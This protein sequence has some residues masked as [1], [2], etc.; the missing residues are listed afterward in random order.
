MSLQKGMMMT[1]KQRFPLESADPTTTGSVDVGQGVLITMGTVSV[2]VFIVGVLVAIGLG[3]TTS[4]WVTGLN[5]IN[6]PFDRDMARLL[7][8]QAETERL[9][10]E[11]PEGDLRNFFDDNWWMV[12]AA[13]NTRQFQ[14]DASQVTAGA[15]PNYAFPDQSG[16]VV[17]EETFPPQLTEFPE[18]VFAIVGDPDTTTRIQFDLT[19]IPSGVARQYQW[20]DEDGVVAM[21]DDVNVLTGNTTV[22]M[23]TCFMLVNGVDNT[24]TMQFNAGLLT[25]A[26]LRTFTFPPAGGELWL[27]DQPQ[28]ISQKNFD[29]SNTFVKAS[30]PDDVVYEGDVQ[31]ISNKTMDTSNSFVLWDDALTVEAASG[32]GLQFNASLLSDARFYATPDEDGILA[33]EQDLPPLPPI[34]TSFSDDEFAVFNAADDSKVLKFDASDV[35]SGQTRVMGIPDENGRIITA[36]R[37]GRRYLANMDAGSSDPLPEGFFFAPESCNTAGYLLAD[38]SGSGVSGKCE[39]VA[40]VTGLYS[41]NGGCMY[42]SRLESVAHYAAAQVGVRIGSTLYV[43]NSGREKNLS[44]SRMSLAG[45]YIS[46]GTI[47]RL[48]CRYR[49]RTSGFQDWSQFADTVQFQLGVRLITPL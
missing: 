14:F 48:S 40:P 18:N 33:L 27:N 1:K 39:Y 43:G 2:M 41:I 8:F 31:P 46:A 42:W 25:T 19:I 28:T 15:I 10:D 4:L 29:D 7:A 24:K 45:I 47:V 38:P 37:D 16:T 17:L 23:D 20:P 26:T 11:V 44:Q 22:F 32:D 12:H 9:E 30:L 35:P 49:Q 34:D 21:Q 36:W 5:R 6:D 13:D 3:I